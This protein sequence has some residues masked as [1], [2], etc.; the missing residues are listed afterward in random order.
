MNAMVFMLAWYTLPI[1]A[2]AVARYCKEPLLHLVVI[3]L[4]MVVGYFLVLATVVA[5]DAE[6]RARMEAFDLNRDGRID[7]SERTEE[8][9]R[10]ILDHGRDTGRA[11]AHILG[12]PLTAVWYSF[13]FGVLYSGEWLIKKLF[14]SSRVTRNRMPHSDHGSG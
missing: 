9:D 4:T 6:D 1:V 11:L 10:A 14:R 8:V 13:L 3:G 12:I 2:Y 5:A 7:D